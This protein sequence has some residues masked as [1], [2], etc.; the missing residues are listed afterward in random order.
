M[1][2]NVDVKVTISPSNRKKYEKMTGKS[3]KN[4]QTGEWRLLAC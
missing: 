3:L 2:K 4:K 1:F